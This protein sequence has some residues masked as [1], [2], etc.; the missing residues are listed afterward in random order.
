MRHRGR[1][2]RLARLV[3]VAL[4][5]VISSTPP[6]SASCAGRDAPQIVADSDVVLTGRL[7]QIDD[8]APNYAP[9]DVAWTIEVLSV[10]KGQAPPTA[11][12]V[13]TTYTH[14]DVSAG[15]TYVFALEV[16]GNGLRAGGCQDLAAIGSAEA[17]ALVGAA[18]SGGPP[19]A[20]GAVPGSA[21]IEQRPSDGWWASPWG[22]VL[23][24]LVGLLLLCIGGVGLAV[25]VGLLVGRHRG[26]TRTDGPVAEPDSTGTPF[27]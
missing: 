23:V 8:P 13:A 21:E 4:A 7:A 17:A 11:H 18:G 15:G 25:L 14:E 24:G 22:M 3:A 27:K 12:V 26:R 9:Y 6:A 10:H 16:N 19:G 5:S 2:G 20:S 1:A